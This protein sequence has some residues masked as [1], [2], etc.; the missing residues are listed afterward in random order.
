MAPVNFE[1]QNLALDQ[2][3]VENHCSKSTKLKL[4]GVE[5]AIFSEKKTKKKHNCSVAGGFTTAPVCD[6][7]AHELSP[8]AQYGAQLRNVWQQNEIIIFKVLFLSFFDQ[9][10]LKSIFRICH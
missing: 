3:Q 1:V 2:K 9:T 4:K 6:A 5:I 8:F 7:H 10:V